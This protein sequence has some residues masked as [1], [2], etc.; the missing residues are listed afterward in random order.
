MENFGK[1]KSIFGDI[2]EVEFFGE[3]LFAKEILVL[4]ENPEIKLEVVGAIQK[5]CFLALC[6][7]GKEKIKRGDLILRTRSCLQVKVGKQL[8]GRVINLFGEEIDGLG[9]IEGEIEKEIEQ[10]SPPYSKTV[11]IKNL[12]E[13][14]IKAIDF[15]APL[16]E[17]GKLGIFGG[18]GLGKTVLLLELMHNLVSAKRGLIVFAG[19]GE[20]IREGAELYEALKESGVL[21][22]AVL[23]FGEM[24]KPAV[25]RYKVGLVAVTLAE[26]FR[27]VLKENVFFFVDNIYRFLQAGN[28]LSTLL[29]HIPSEGGYQPT[30]ASE[31]GNFQERLVATNDASLTSIEAIYVPAD[32]ITDPAVQATLPYFDSTIFFSREVYQEGRLPAI[33][34][35]ATTSSLISPEILGEKHYFALIEAKKV[36]ERYRELQ[37]IVAILGEAELALEDRLIY[38]RAKKILNFMTQYFFSVQDQTGKTGQYVPRQKTIEGIEKILAGDCDGMPDEAFLYIGSLDELKK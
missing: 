5:N 20:R 33:D 31:I 15:F 18:A 2:V 4:K 13:T 36:L 26:Y 7:R 10:H 38:H 8:L 23:V 11:P 22:S 9:K 21:N 3:N 28:E 16:A 24:D 14:G 12:M 25:I 17:G 29:G 30:L 6:L 34:L 37:K 27:D 35:L 19:I 1:I 32:D